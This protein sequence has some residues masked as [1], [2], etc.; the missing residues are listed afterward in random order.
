MLQAL[1]RRKAQWLV[2]ESASQPTIG[3]GG[4]T[5]EESLER[6]LEQGY[7]L[8]E[9][10]LTAMVFGRLCYLPSETFWRLL[11]NACTP[12]LAAMDGVIEERAFW[13]RLP[14]RIHDSASERQ[15]E[16]DLII[17]SGTID[18]ILEAKRR[19]G[20]DLQRPDQLAKEWVAWLQLPAEQ[21][22][23]NGLL[24]AVGGFGRITEDAVATFR[25][26]IAA[27]VAAL[28]GETGD[29]P[30]LA[31]AW[32]SLRKV[33]EDERRTAAANERFL[34]EDVLAALD[35]HE[36]LW[37]APLWFADF[38]GE[39]RIV[40]PLDLKAAA[41]LAALDVHE[42]SSRAPR[43]FASFPDEVRTVT[44]LDLRAAEVLS[45]EPT[46]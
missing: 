25:G 5:D 23:E 11:S 9:D 26:H 1:R 21:R 24:L 29:L 16:P 2:S 39:I 42:A 8:N 17:R 3:N 33:L 6:E 35:L 20:S 43:W 7:Q 34:F 31:V 4:D 41:A 46:L 15:V 44:P 14:L 38:P 45:I 22:S 19:D 40:M 13:P 18:L 12:H 30:F 10:T 32:S 36:V 37:R 27:E 28:G